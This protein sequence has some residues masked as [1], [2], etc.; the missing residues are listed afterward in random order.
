MNGAMGFVL[1]TRMHLG[2]SRYQD[3]KFAF[4]FQ[5]DAVLEVEHIIDPKT[6]SQLHQ[7]KLL[8]LNTFTYCSLLI[9]PSSAADAAVS[10]K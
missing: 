2:I 6:D 8:K 9:L 5:Q 10:P 4:D 1:T 3:R 7:F